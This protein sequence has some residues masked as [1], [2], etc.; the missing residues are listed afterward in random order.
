MKIT[1]ILKIIGALHAV[2]GIILVSFLFIPNDIAAEIVGASDAEN[3]LWFKTPI[4]VVA[5][6]NLGIAILLIIS[7]S[8]QDSSSAKLV[9]KGETAIMLCIFLGALFNH[10]S[11]LTSIGPPKLLWVMIVFNMSLSFYGYFRGK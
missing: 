11:S 10:F 6:M 8:M 1:S 7:S 4:T 9:L 5:F 2:L 3:I